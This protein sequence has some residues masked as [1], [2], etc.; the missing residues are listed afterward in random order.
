MNSLTRTRPFTLEEFHRM[1]HVGIL[2]EIDRVELI[3]G[4]LI[5][6]TPIGPRHAACVDT[7]TRLFVQQAPEQVV[8]RVQ[9]PL[10]LNLQTEV[11]PDLALLRP[12]DHGY[13]TQNPEP[14]D[15]LLVIEVADTTLEKDR[16]EKLPKYAKAGIPEVWV[17]DVDHNHI[18]VC[19]ELLNSQYLST[20]TFSPGTEISPSTL[21]NIHIPTTEILK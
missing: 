17:V 10:V 15:V 3:E 2:T 20:K 19:H 11:Y 12:R 18:Q 16:D 21:P 1:A 7:L 9:N 6:M 8:V 14:E 13:R 4:E 5:P